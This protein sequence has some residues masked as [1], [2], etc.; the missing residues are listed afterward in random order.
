MPDLETR[1]VAAD[2]SEPRE[3]SGRPGRPAAPR[4][5]SATPAAAA[6]VVSSFLWGA[7]FVVIRDSVDHISPLS[8]ITIRFGAASLILAM[9]ALVLRRR[10]SRQA[11]VG[12]AVAGAAA[13]GAFLFQAI[14]L[15]ETSA[16]TSAF[17]TAIGTLLAGLF[18]WP[19]LGQRP[20]ARIALALAIA[21][22]GA[23]L[24]ADHAGS[25]LSAGEWWTALGAFCFG[26]QVV[27]LARFAPSA[28]PLVL[29]WMQA[30]TVFL[31]VGPFAWGR[32]AGDL[33]SAGLWRV[34]Y[35]VVAGT[36]VAPLLQVFAQSR[37]S[38]A[39]TA[40]LLALE[41]VFA[42]G[43]A[44]TFGA[45]RFPARWFA[46]AALILCAVLFAET[47]PASREPSARRARR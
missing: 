8:L 24:L 31:L 30:L 20:G 39:R 1:R 21:A 36:V 7:T 37:I 22:T 12:G 6:V 25:G 47:G 41:P 15:T 19:M 28:D 17:L 34:G 9:L 23:L 18:A 32:P 26:L 2:P 45:E 10:P 16:G 11:V 42:L 4:A 33:A 40:L 46:G 27:A 35:L 43:F 38:A 13:A 3:P 14:G 5:D 29:A 44:L